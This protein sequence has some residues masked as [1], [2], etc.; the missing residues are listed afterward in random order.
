MKIYAFANTNSITQSNT[1]RLPTE[2]QINARFIF[3]F[4]M[5]HDVNEATTSRLELIKTCPKALRK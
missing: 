5:N 2:I 4:S 3:K 1:I